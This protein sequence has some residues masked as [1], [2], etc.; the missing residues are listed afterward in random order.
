MSKLKLLKENWTLSLF[1]VAD[2]DFVQ[3][4]RV[5]LTDSL[6]RLSVQ[7]KYAP[8]HVQISRFVE[9]VFAGPQT[10]VEQYRLV[11]LTDDARVLQG[12]LQIRFFAECADL[13][14]I[15]VDSALRGKGYAGEMMDFVLAELGSCNVRRLLLEVGVDNAPAIH[16]YNR[17]G[18]REISR[19]KGYYRSGEDALVMELNL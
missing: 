5:K 13:D 1:G 9:S 6:L 8:T 4:Q 10:G 16:F 7:S 11:T 2:S 15:I 3:E 14:F 19:R 12:F 17:L 18:F